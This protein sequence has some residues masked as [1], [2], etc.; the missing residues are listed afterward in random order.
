MSRHRPD[1]EIIKEGYE[2]T[3][4][5]SATDELARVAVRPVSV[6]AGLRSRKLIRPWRSK[7]IYSS[8]V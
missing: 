6:S 2:I 7:M 4:A 5:A 8:Q 1:R 3:Y